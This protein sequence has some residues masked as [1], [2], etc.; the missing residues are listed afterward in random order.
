MI[1]H[2]ED[3]MIRTA[4]EELRGQA[5]FLKVLGSY[6]MAEEMKNEKK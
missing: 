1:G 5:V 6:P 3:E 4:I 2:L